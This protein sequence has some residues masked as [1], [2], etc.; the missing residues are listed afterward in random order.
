MLL[1]WPVDI[2][3]IPIKAAMAPDSFGY[4]IENGIADKFEKDNV[5]WSGV[6]DFAAPDHPMLSFMTK[7]RARSLA[8]FLA[9]AVQRRP[10]QILGCHRNSKL[11]IRLIT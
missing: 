10:V 7:N 2:S 4:G 9:K 1:P 11:N 6:V 5:G 3:C 8:P